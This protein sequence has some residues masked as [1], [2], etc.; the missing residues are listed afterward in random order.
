MELGE[1]I[2]EIRI[3]KGISQAD[4]CMN[5]TTQSNYSKFELGKIEI[6][7]NS[8]FTIIKNLDIG[9]EEF[10]LLYEVEFKDETNDLITNFFRL[11]SNQPSELNNLRSKALLYQKE[12][13]KENPTLNN[14][15]QLSYGLEIIAL[16]EEYEE[17]ISIASPIWEKLKKRDRWYIREIS[18]LN[19]ILYIF[20][21]D[22]AEEIVKRSIKILETYRD[23]NYITSLKLNFLINIS[24]LSI[25]NKDFIK[26]IKYLDLSIQ[27]SNNIS[28]VLY[29]KISQ[30][31]L[32]YCMASLDEPF[33]EELI[34]IIM[35]FVSTNS[36]PIFEQLK[37]EA[38]KY[39]TNPD[40][41]RTLDQYEQKVNSIL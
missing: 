23:T 25:K 19:N 2:K 14:I 5:A 31:R 7:A 4:A 22:T 12:F 21:F 28:I 16:K 9:L 37:K 8:L 20:P 10:V 15:I 36:L 3:Q 26:A 1:F 27:K 17:A 40:F 39:C 29:K 38:E 35:Y 41:L 11:G 18:L 6:S 13:K 34:S 24:L 33:E 30:M 32:A